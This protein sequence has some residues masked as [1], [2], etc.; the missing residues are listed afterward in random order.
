MKKEKKKDLND[1]IQILLQFK[2][3]SQLILEN[4]SYNMCKKLYI[5]RENN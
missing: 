3:S 4:L 1:K 5:D 2:G